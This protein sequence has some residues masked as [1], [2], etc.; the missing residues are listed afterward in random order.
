MLHSIAPGVLPSIY[1]HP[2]KRHDLESESLAI[3]HWSLG[4]VNS[5]KNHDSP[6]HLMTNRQWPI[7]NGFALS[8][9]SHF[10]NPQLSKS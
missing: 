6:R 10:S 5:V 7:P 3:G 8:G 1:S 9:I 4:I 2:V